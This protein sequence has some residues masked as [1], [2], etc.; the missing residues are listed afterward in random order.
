[1]A[2]LFTLLVIAGFALKVSASAPGSRITEFWAWLC[3]LVASILWGVTQ[4]GGA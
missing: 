1:M 3:W 4:F 2:L